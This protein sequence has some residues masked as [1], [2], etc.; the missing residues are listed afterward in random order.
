M[1]G[2]PRL[3][4]EDHT[5]FEAVLDVALNTGDV[6]S[7][8]RTDPTGRAGAQLRIQALGAAD[9]ITAAAA[10][11][12]AVYLTTRD[13][14]RPPDLKRSTGEGTVLPALMVLTP[15]LAAA[16]A[17]VL[18]LLGYVLQVADA[19][20]SFPASLVTAG[21]VLALIAV[22]STLVALTALVRTALHQRG[23]RPSA[24]RVEQARLAWQQ[25]LLDR[26]M[27]P[28]LRGCVRRDP[29]PGSAITQPPVHE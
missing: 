19:S 10:D 21:W 5:D 26:G 14:A 16:S 2:P 28:Y 23:G 4:P 11:A 29:L 27:L 3:R 6:C 8:L 1:A 7:V 24:D 13:S 17:A 25:A 12:Y 18:L 15:L 20:G 9:E 22:V